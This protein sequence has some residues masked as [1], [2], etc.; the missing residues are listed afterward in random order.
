[1][2]HRPV[3]LL[4]F[5]RSLWLRISDTPKPL[6]IAQEDHVRKQCVAIQ[7]TPP[8]TETP[9]VVSPRMSSS[10][11]YD[12]IFI[13]HSCLL[14]SAWFKERLI[15]QHIDNIRHS[16]ACLFHF[17]KTSSPFSNTSRATD[18]PSNSAIGSCTF[19]SPHGYG[20][21]GADFSTYGDSA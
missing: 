6:N 9:P 19:A 4:K 21:C 20:A 2:Q 15:K 18:V 1:M 10:R 12:S 5:D 7:L 13:F 17:T 11:L 3:R 14:L 8:L 16:H